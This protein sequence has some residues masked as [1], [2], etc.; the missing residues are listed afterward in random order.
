MV[1]ASPA[2]VAALPNLPLVV[3]PYAR[4]DARNTPAESSWKRGKSVV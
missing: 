2:V 4:I 1:A 3:A